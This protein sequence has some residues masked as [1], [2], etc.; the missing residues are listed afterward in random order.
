MLL[1]I[2]L[3][4]LI[5]R[6]LLRQQEIAEKG[7][8]AAATLLEYWDTGTTINDDPQVGMLLE[9]HPVGSIP[10]QAKLTTVIPRL[11]VGMLKPGANLQVSYLAER[12]QDLAFI[13]FDM[14]VEEPGETGQPGVVTLW[15]ETRKARLAE[16]DELYNRRMIGD[17]DYRRRR[18]ELLE[19]AGKSQEPV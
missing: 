15:N 13:S 11:S 4:L 8:S 16:L 18:E 7:Q 17:S 10:Y 2:G 3:P 12:P 19:Q 14:P 6:P 1:S 9:V 5:L